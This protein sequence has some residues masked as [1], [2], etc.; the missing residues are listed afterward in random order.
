MFDIRSL[1]WLDQILK[2]RVDLPKL[3]EEVIVEIEQY[4]VFQVG[5]CKLCSKRNVWHNGVIVRHVWYCGLTCANKILYCTDNFNR[6]FS[7][8]YDGGPGG[9]IA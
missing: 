5:K 3:P 8:R 1:I 2:K 9:G 4:L 6:F 7:N